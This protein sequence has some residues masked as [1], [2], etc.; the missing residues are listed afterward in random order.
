MSLLR[1]LD[2]DMILGLFDMQAVG[3][4]YNKELEMTKDKLSSGDE[5]IF[6]SFENYFAPIKMIEQT[7]ENLTSNQAL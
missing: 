1:H 2:W 7:S 3:N 6:D 4:Y 5:I